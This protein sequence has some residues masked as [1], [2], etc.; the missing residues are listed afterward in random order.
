V[1]TDECAVMRKRQRKERAKGVSEWVEQGYV[2]E[3]LLEG[4]RLR[5]KATRG[6]KL[7]EREEKN[8]S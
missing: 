2:R 5:K 8:L 3:D 6:A 7:K 1:G 4:F